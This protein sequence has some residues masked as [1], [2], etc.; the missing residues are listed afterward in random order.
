MDSG[1]SPSV[2][3]ICALIYLELFV[4]YA[5]DT[6]T[7]ALDTVYT[8]DP[9]SLHSS[10][11]LSTCNL[12]F[13]AS[14]SQLSFTHSPFSLLLLRTCC[15]LLAC[16]HPTAFIALYAYDSCGFCTWLSIGVDTWI[17]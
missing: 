9:I 11:H 14:P 15:S 5:G 8:E 10:K 12:P 7:L 1:V 17:Q 16:L 6:N 13:V 3:G 2:S 4:G